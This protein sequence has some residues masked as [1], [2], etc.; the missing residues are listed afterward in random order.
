MS[1]SMLI[2]YVFE[3]KTHTP[4]PYSTKHSEMCPVGT[5]FADAMKYWPVEPNRGPFEIGLRWPSYAWPGGYEIH[6]LTK[7]CGTLCHQ[8]ANANLEQTI[9]DD[10]Q[11]EIISSD[12]HWEGSPLQCDHCYRD[13]VSAYGGDEIDSE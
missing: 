9:G 11:W 3:Y 6:Y 13:I 2:E 7:D 5:S 8:C 10:P 12:I 4:F 1:K